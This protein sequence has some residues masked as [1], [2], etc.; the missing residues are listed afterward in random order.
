MKQQ[1]V[2][3]FAFFISIPALFLLNIGIYYSLIPIL[4]TAATP[5]IWWLI[6]GFAI[7]VSLSP[8]FSRGPVY[9]FLHET[10]HAIVASL[11]GNKWKRM[12]IN[13]DEGS[14]EYSYT[15]K[16]AHLNAFIS[17]AP[18]WFPLLTIP[19]ALLALPG[20]APEA[21]RLIVGVTLGLDFV[22]GIKDLGPHQTDLSLV[23][24]G[25]KIATLYVLFMIGIVLGLA[26]TWGAFGVAGFKEIA[27]RTFEMLIEFTHQ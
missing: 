15:K 17:L 11:A 6:G 23:R 2:G 18:Y 21:M 1:K 10:K 9:V 19:A 8:L 14:Y 20:K 13:G 22:T 16:T 26:L 24:G 5:F 3:G 4:F 12:K 25:A 7:G 27:F